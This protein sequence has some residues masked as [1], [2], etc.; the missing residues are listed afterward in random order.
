MTPRMM[1]EKIL[2]KGNRQESQAHTWLFVTLSFRGW[3]GVY[4]V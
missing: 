3:A 1:I 4:R 2:K